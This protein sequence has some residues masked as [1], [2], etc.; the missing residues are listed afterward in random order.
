M[1][2]VKADSDAFQNNENDELIAVRI[3]RDTDA[4]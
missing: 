4:L 2:D 1:K 3:R